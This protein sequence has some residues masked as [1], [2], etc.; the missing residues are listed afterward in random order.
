MLEAPILVPPIPV[1][2]RKARRQ[3]ERPPLM[4]VVREK[5][6]LG[7]LAA[8]HRSWLKGQA[9]ILCGNAP[10]AEDL[11]QE[12]ITKF[13][14]KYQYE[15]H[16]L[17]RQKAEALLTEILTNSFNDQC[18]RRKVR[19][20]NAHDPLLG[21]RLHAIPRPS[22]P[23]LAETVTSEQVADSLRQF[24]PEMQKTYKLLSEG[25]S[26]EEIARQCG[27]T[28]GTARKR[29]HDIRAKLRALLTAGRN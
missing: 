19:D 24:S 28:V 18:R 13:L 11:V 14:T 23:S 9:M 29:V 20:R 6:R 3:E 4:S 27:I 26:Y 16:G 15:G 8:G 25:M 1:L 21:E 7:D 12:A 22:E 2:E 5:Q 10:D 17:D